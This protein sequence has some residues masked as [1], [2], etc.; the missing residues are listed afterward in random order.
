MS[1]FVAGLKIADLVGM[2][3]AGRRFVEAIE[4]E[5]VSA[6]STRHFV[7]GCT[8]NDHVVA[9]S[10]DDIFNVDQDILAYGIAEPPC[11]Q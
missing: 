1:Y 4:P 5:R 8:V 9:A 6:V 7:A 11:W 3:R 2:F 10:S